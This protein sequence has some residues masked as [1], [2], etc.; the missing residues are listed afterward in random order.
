VPLRGDRVDAEAARTQRRRASWRSGVSKTCHL[1]SLSLVEAEVGTN[2]ADDGIQRVLAKEREGERNQAWGVHLACSSAQIIDG[3]RVD[4]RC[5]SWSVYLAA[6]ID[7]GGVR[8][9][10]ANERRGQR[11]LSASVLRGTGDNSW[12]CGDADLHDGGEK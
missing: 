6:T 7:A 3:S 4:Q 2:L 10:G 11:V 1:V 5:S 9:R 8:G 12:C